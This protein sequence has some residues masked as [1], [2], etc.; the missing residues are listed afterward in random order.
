MGTQA[1]LIELIDALPAEAFD[2]HVF[3]VTAT[4]ANSLAPSVS[5]GRWAPP[6]RPGMRTSILYTSF[7]ADCALAE[8]CS[9]LVLLD[10]LPSVEK[11]KVSR[12]EASASRTLRLA[13]ADLA[14]LGVDLTRYGERDYVGTQQI[15]EAASQVGIDGLI[16]P[17]ARWP[18]DNLMI[19]TDNLS[20][21]AKLAVVSSE[22]VVRRE[23]ARVNGL[24]TPDARP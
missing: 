10:P 4:T 18:G 14:T 15:G 20:P 17:S 12:L 23:W 8:V 3:R 13:R 9:Y 7:E 21:T 24:L 5:G 6:K 16:A 2:G 11:L 19:F 1:S 22:E